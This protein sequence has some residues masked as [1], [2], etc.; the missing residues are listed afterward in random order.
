MRSGGGCGVNIGETLAE[1]RRAAG[2]TV[3]QVSQQARV[4]EAII[5]R[6]ED[7]DFS[8]CGGDD[9][10]RGYIRIVARAVGADEEP[11]IEEYSTL[12][13]GPQTTTD[14]LREPVTPVRVGTRPRL[15]WVAVLVL[16][17]LA[18]AVY[19]LQTGFSQVTKATPS[20]RA[21][22]AAHHISARPLRAHLVHQPAAPPGQHIPG[23]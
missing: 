21:H 15:N 22:P 14:D 12:R 6:V 16:V 13:P 1:A 11:L 20:A 7:D 18:L 9:Y 17:W 19:D 10:A 23:R 3:A 8:A 2:L 4:R 5:T